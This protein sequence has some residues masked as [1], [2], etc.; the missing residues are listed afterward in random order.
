MA[1]PL[2]G[3]SD[4]F[5]T[6]QRFVEQYTIQFSWNN[7]SNF[8]MKKDKFLTDMCCLSFSYNLFIL[9]SLNSIVYGFC[10]IIVNPSREGVKEKCSRI[11]I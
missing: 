3:F 5:L 4:F 1:I 8:E 2:I 6:K 9:Q 10:V 7:N 11:L